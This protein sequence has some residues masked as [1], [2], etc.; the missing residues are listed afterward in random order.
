MYTLFTTQNL[1]FFLYYTFIAYSKKTFFYG[2]IFPQ[3]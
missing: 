1:P 2:E 3:N